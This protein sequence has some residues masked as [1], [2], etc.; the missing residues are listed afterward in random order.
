M[1]EDRERF[2]LPGQTG[3]R[4]AG[5]RLYL[6]LHVHCYLVD[7]ISLRTKRSNNRVIIITTTMNFHNETILIF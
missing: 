2:C 4:K 6:S 7:S 3:G 5:E 1:V